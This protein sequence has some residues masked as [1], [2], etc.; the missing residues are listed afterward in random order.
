MSALTDVV[1]R[2]L[3]RACRVDTQKVC[4]A[5]RRVAAEAA[6][7]EDRGDV[8]GA[9]MEP[10]F[11]MDLLSDEACE[12]GGE[13]VCLAVGDALFLAREDRLVAALEADWRALTGG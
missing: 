6:D 3:A 8:L 4:A 11:A 5:T 7:T 10:L 1:E 2:A 13:A 12:H 9:R